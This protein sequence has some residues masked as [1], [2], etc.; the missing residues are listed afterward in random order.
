MQHYI[1]IYIYICVCVCVFV[2]ELIYDI[3]IFFLSLLIYFISLN[4]LN[5][6]YI[7]Y[8]LTLIKYHAF[9]SLKT[10]SNL[11]I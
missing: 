7:V 6:I 8:K 11:H 1:S 4:N 5:Q 9:H 10:I 2:D 3:T